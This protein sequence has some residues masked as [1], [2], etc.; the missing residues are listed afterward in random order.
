MA[1]IKNTHFKHLKIMA[2]CIDEKA[3]KRALLECEESE[4]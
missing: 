3:R 4:Y 2:G 1:T